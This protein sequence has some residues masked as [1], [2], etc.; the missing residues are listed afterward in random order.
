MSRVFVSYRRA[1]GAYGVGWLA[2]RLR[3]LDLITGVETAFHDA[4]LR[5]GDDFPDALEREIAGSDL[6]VA[7]IGPMWRGDTGDVPARIEDADDWV[8]REIAAAF[9]HGIRVVPVL[10]DGAEHPLASEIH[11]SISAIARLH[12]LPFTDGREL[13]T[14]VEHVG[15]HLDELDR[16]RARLA[17]LE[18][19]V[20]VPPLERL[21]RLIAGAAA[22][23]VLGTGLACTSLFAGVD[24][25]AALRTTT[26]YD[27]YIPV[28]IVLGVASGA[29]G[30]FGLVLMRRL[31]HEVVF[32]WA[33]FCFTY[34]AAAGI[35]AILVL[36]AQSGHL[37]LTTS[38]SIS[39]GPLRGWLNFS[40]AAFVIIP[41][42]I[43][44][45]A[46]MLAE[47]RSGAHEIGR[48]VQLLPL[49]RDTERWGVVGI[50]SILTLGTMAGAAL[51]GAA[52]EAEEV[53]RFEP[54]PIVGFA[55]IL[56]ALIIFVHSAMITRLRDRQDDLVSALS[57]LP[58]RY[59]EN[60]LPRL[61][62]HAFDD[63]GWGFRVVLAAPVLSATVAAIAIGAMHL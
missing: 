60:A 26:G 14:I 50:S 23:A 30:V 39:S 47:P 55:A 56:S 25:D 40:L 11:P 61:V 2:D 46:P 33:R 37:L 27:W 38:D 43:C 20:E 49:M 45:V 63:G 58:P 9:T 31:L 17:G 1:D 35:A 51:V 32:D 44:V 52:L 62:A 5:A 54:I 41:W 29:F 12:A 10:M 18:E 36:S 42:S 19:P 48:E 28:L 6:M 34:L 24:G 59:R 16:D 15:S 13:D 8:V 57:G 3:T 4:A 53:D 22:A 7:V 21:P